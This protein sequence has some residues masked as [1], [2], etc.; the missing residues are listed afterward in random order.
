MKHSFRAPRSART[1]ASSLGARLL[2]D[3]C[4]SAP[5]PEMQFYGNDHRQEYRSNAEL[6]ERSGLPLSEFAGRYPGQTFYVCSA[7]Y[8]I[9]N[10]SR[11]LECRGALA[12][13][14][15]DAE[16]FEG[17]TDA[18]DVMFAEYLVATGAHDAAFELALG[19]HD[20][21][22]DKQPGAGSVLS[23]ALFSSSFGEMDARSTNSGLPSLLSGS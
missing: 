9:R 15:R 3:G 19:I 18:L 12:V 16:G 13:S 14:V 1:A 4:A 6:Y 17:R 22:L 21:G 7:Y 20:R 5:Y 11:F 23:T 8:K 10:Y 2:L